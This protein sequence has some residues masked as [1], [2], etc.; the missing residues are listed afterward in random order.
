MSRRRNDLFYLVSFNTNTFQYS[1]LS[2]F[3]IRIQLVHSK[4]NCYTQS[5]SCIRTT[6]HRVS[7]QPE[8]P[9][10]HMSKCGPYFY[11]IFNYFTKKLFLADFRWSSAHWRLINNVYIIL[12]YRNWFALL[13]WKKF[14]NHQITRISYEKFQ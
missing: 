10:N 4:F 5:H 13:K 2:A 1:H 8:K 3:I 11:A 7:F 14:R 9:I 12:G 6:T